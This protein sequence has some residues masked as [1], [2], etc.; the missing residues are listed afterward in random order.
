MD[1]LGTVYAVISEQYDHSTTESH[2]N[3]K[4]NTIGYTLTGN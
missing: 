4:L 3:F 1:S 2:Q